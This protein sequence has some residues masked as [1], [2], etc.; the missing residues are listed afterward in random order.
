MEV[1]IVGLILCL[2]PWKYC[3]MYISNLFSHKNYYNLSGHGNLLTI[4]NVAVSV[5]WQ[6]QTY[7]LFS[8]EVLEKI[9]LTHKV[10]RWACADDLGLFF[11]LE[12]MPAGSD[13]LLL[14]CPSP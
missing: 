14:V 9:E 12:G 10:C 11:A 2:K 3:S 5:L 13:Q 6:K 1:E 7:T 8:V 4:L